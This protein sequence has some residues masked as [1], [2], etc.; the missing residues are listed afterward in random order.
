[1]RRSSK[2]LVLVAIIILTFATFPAASPAGTECADANGNG[3]ITVTDMGFLITYL[4][5][6]GPA[7][8][9]RAEAI[10]GYKFVTINDIELMFNWA[11]LSGP[12][13]TCPEILDSILPVTEDSLF[14]RNAPVISGETT[15]RIDLWLVPVTQIYACSFGFTY[16]A[17]L[18]SVTLDSISIQGLTNLAKYSFVMNID[19]VG[20]KGNV[21]VWRGDITAAQVGIGYLAKLYF[22]HAAAPSTG[23]H[24]WIDTTSY[25][26]PWLNSNPIVFSKDGYLPVL[27]NIVEINSYGICGDINGDGIINILDVSCG[28]NYLYKGGCDV[29]PISVIDVTRDGAF[30]I[31]DISFLINYLYRFGPTLNCL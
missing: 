1:M 9:S 20:Q 29:Q 31:L 27:P 23:R 11:F 21:T 19:N 25:S 7:P 17:D 30:N 14:I 15:H 10:D 13:P 12:P 18:S 26:M 2:I 4:L 22:S 28:I 5:K 16:S 3:S 8:L 6:G 24:V